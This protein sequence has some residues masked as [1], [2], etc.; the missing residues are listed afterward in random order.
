MGLKE[1]YG[2]ASVKSASEMAQEL[3]GVSLDKR[4]DARKSAG[5]EKALSAIDLVEAE[6]SARKVSRHGKTKQWGVRLD[7]AVLDLVK[8]NSKNHTQDA[9]AMIELYAS[10]RGWE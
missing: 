3:S 4:T 5:V 9:E 2:A 10:L 7:E 1:Q 6:K 8:R